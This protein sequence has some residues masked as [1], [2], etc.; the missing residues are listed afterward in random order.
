LLGASDLAKILH[1]DIQF[2]VIEDET[3][4]NFV[5]RLLQRN[6]KLRI[7]I[8]EVGKHPFLG[9]RPKLNINF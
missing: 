1:Q 6:V 9:G 7:S 5:E 2:E 3:A 8:D 4:R